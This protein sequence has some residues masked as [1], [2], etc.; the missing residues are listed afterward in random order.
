MYPNTLLTEVREEIRRTEAYINSARYYSAPW[1]H[2]HNVCDTLNL[3]RAKEIRLAAEL[4]AEEERTA[5]L[6]TR[7]VRTGAPVLAT[8]LYVPFGE[9]IFSTSL[10]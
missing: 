8:L 6:T 3:L 2:Q 10:A 9:I 5:N 7:A 1:E 4:A